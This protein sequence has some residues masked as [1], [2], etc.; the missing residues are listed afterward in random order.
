MRILATFLVSVGISALVSCSAAAPSGASDQTLV[1]QSL[2]TVLTKDGKGVCLDSETHGE[3]LGVFRTMMTAPA[4]TRLSLSWFEPG[5]LRPQNDLSDGQIFGEQIG[6]ERV[7]ITAPGQSGEKLPLQ[8]QGQ[9]NGVAAQLSLYMDVNEVA[10]PSS[11]TAPLAISRWWIRNR[12]DSK[13]SPV[14][15]VSNPVVA[16]NVAFVSVK[17]GHWGTTYA[18]QKRSA[19]WAPIAQWSNWIY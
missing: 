10:V 11:P 1:M 9:L 6:A 7:V 19:A 16:K 18:F 8:L 15:T 2:L 13:C 5:P 14:Y 17:A 4:S 12:F 3:P